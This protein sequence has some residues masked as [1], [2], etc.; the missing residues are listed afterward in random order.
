MAWE[1]AMVHLYTPR[2]E[3]ELLL[4]KSVFDGAGIRFF[5][6]N[7]AF[8]SLAV[9]PQIEHWNVKSIYVAEADFEEAIGLVREFHHRTG[10]DHDATPAA[11]YGFGDK[12]R[13]FLEF[14]LFGWF[15]PGRRP[16]RAPE[17]RLIKNDDPR[18]TRPARRQRPPL[19]LLPGGAASGEAPPG[20][21]S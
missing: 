9:G 14:L 3:I 2:S 10:D 15:M 4:L 21:G 6:R 19:R 8:G 11:R 20:A 13:M 18:P 17:L 7:E 12:V 5:V 16:A 1:P